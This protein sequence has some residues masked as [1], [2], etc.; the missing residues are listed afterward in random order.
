MEQGIACDSSWDAGSEYT[1]GTMH[2][3]FTPEGTVIKFDVYDERINPPIHKL[4]ELI[5]DYAALRKYIEIH[6][7]STTPLPL[8]EKQVE[9]GKKYRAIQLIAPKE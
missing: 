3:R 2:T 4:L 5:D 9:Y 6:H 8:D 1:A 7:E